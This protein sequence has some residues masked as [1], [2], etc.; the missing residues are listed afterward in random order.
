[1]G[2]IPHLYTIG[3]QFHAGVCQL[4]K[5]RVPLHTELGNVLAHIAVMPGLKPVAGD[6]LLPLWIA[7]DKSVLRTCLLYTSDA[8]DE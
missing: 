6:P 7:E 4:L 1:M 3:G 5:L 2:R 8:A